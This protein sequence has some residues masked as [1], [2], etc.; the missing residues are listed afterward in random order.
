MLGCLLAS[1]REQE[2]RPMAMMAGTNNKI[3]M[4]LK[5]FV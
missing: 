1:S 4:V 2:M 3:L 5:F